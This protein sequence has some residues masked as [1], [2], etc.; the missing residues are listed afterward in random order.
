MEECKRCDFEHPIHA[1]RAKWLCPVCKRDYSLE[2]YFYYSSRHNS[3]EKINKE[4][5][6]GRT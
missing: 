3:E 6:N 1:A 2:Y 5:K 4:L